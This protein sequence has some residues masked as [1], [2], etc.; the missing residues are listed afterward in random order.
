MFRESPLSFCRS[1]SYSAARDRDNGGGSTWRPRERDYQQ[2]HNNQESWRN[3]RAGNYSTPQPLLPHQHFVNHMQQ[4]SAPPNYRNH[5]QYQQRPPPPPPAHYQQT[6]HRRQH[7]R[8][9]NDRQQNGN[10]RDDWHGGH[11]GRRY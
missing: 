4:Y 8:H 10:G 3:G 2:S 9:G 1:G 5:N 7:D 11:R 6:P